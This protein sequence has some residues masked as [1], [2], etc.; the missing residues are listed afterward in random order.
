MGVVPESDSL[1]PFPLRFCLVYDCMMYDALTP[2]GY[3]LWEGHLKT[4][5]TQ[6]KRRIQCRHHEPNH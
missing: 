4:N 5:P 6:S 1:S 3:L 2:D